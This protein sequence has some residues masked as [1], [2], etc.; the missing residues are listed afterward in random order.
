LLPVKD[1]EKAFITTDHILTLNISAFV[2]THLFTTVLQTDELPSIR[3]RIHENTSLQSSTL[4]PADEPRLLV[5]K[6]QRLVFN[7]NQTILKLWLATCALPWLGRGSF[8]ET[9]AAQNKNFILHFE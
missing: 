3:W 6:W 7:S 8:P 5:F 4:F 9:V 1:D 2:C